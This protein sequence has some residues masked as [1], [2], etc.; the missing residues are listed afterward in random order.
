M[1]N[2][3]NVEQTA[4]SPAGTQGDK[5]ETA[6]YGKFKSPDELLNA[7][8]ALEAEFTRRSQR[9]K[10]LEGKLES[11]RIEEEWTEKLKTLHE[12]YP[13]SKGLS[14]EI[15]EYLKAN[16]SMIGEKDCLEKALLNVLA[17][18]SSFSPSPEKARNTSP[19]GADAQTVSNEEKDAGRRVP[20]PKLPVSVGMPPANPF[21]RP[22]TVAEAG[23]LAAEHFKKLKGE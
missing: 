11:G 9:I 18:R 6:S 10:E 13:V 23:K 12:K 5:T 14:K 16:E 3:L 17:E 22:S 4:L 21:R 15:G 20:P 8:N 19:D 2:D 7:Y 1:E